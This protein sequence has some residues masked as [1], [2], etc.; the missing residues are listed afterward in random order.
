MKK[1]VYSI[2]ALAMTAMTF[3]SCE[4]VPMPYNDPNNYQD[5]EEILPEGTYMEESFS[6]DFGAFQVKT[7]KGTPWIIS[8]STATATGYNSSDKTN[9]ES[10]SYLVS[11]E[12]DLT[13]AT[14]AYLTFEYIL[15]YVS[16]DGENSVLITDEYNGDPE[17]TDWEDI[18]GELTEG[19]DWNTFATYARQIDRKYL[20]KSIRV[21]L[22][23]NA[24]ANGSRTWEVKNI[25]IR[26]GKAEE[27]GNDDPIAPTEG[28][29]SGTK[30]DP[31]NVAAA[32]SVIEQT[33]EKATG[34]VYVKGVVSEIEAIE[35]EFGNATYYISDDGATGKQLYIYRSSGLGGESIKKDDYLKKKDEVI[36]CGKLVNFKGNTP[37]MTQG[38]YIYSLN[39]KE[40]AKD[41]P[42]DITGESKGNGTKASPYNVPA[43]L[44]FIQTLGSS[45]S[46]E[47][48]VEG[49]I[50]KIDNVETKEY[51]NATFYI[52]EDGK[53]SSSQ[54]Q[55]FRAKYLENKQFTSASQIKKGD[56]VVVYGKLVNFKG[57][58]PEMTQ[59]GYIYSL[60]GETKPKQEEK[61]TEDGKK[62]G[63]LDGKVLTV[64]SSDFGFSGTTYVGT[65]TLVDGTTISFSQNEG[66]DAPKYMSSGKYIRLNS[67]NSMTINAGKKTISR[68]TIFCAAN[69]SEVYNAEGEVEV[70]SGDSSFQ[71]D[72][73]IY[74]ID[75]GT[76]TATNANTTTGARG[77]LRILGLEI[78]Y[79]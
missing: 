8:Y 32:L 21:A 41:E 72:I 11:P 66:K 3:T 71:N 15:R 74:G 30:E 18:T 13:G 10:E 25:A 61:D 42:Q 39:G 76:L 62:A 34:E 73:Y 64:Y 78:V 51:G 47:V 29:G 19:S 40:A 57:N 16:N 36:V 2:M 28:K 55:I 43:A 38:G 52:S 5:P 60:N 20:G 37:E 45:E 24:S 1:L 56:K 17:T 65:L 53:T 50:S 44:R 26:E 23:Y 49:I 6:K 31:Y 48:Y 14:E 27:A 46:S 35:T 68:V 33:G 77:Q 59:G 4:D 54:L 69:N 7:I 58:T 9:T 75:A 22:Y 63:T 12:I 67:Y 70:S 79:Q